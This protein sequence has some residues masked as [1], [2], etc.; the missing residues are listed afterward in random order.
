VRTCLFAVRACRG[1]ACINSERANFDFLMSRAPDIFRII[2][3]CAGL[4]SRA[5]RLRN[6]FAHSSNHVFGSRICR[7]RQ[8]TNTVQLLQTGKNG[9]IQRLNVHGPCADTNHCIVGNP[10]SEQDISADSVRVSVSVSVR[11]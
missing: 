2:A 9:K 10:G 7:L 6:K 3:S 4:W 8:Q 5:Y 11:A 1:H